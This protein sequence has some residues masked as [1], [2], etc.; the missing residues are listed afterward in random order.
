MGTILMGLIFI[1]G[2]L[3]FININSSN[4]PKFDPRTIEITAVYPGASPVEVEQ[5]II[6]KVE[7]ALQSVQGLRNVTSSSSE[8]NGIIT[9][10]VAEKFDANQVLLK[11][12]NAV[13]G[14]NTFPVGMEKILVTKSEFALEAV[15]ISIRGNIPLHDLLQETRRIET[16]L[17]AKEGVSKINFNGLPKPE[18]EIALDQHK[19]RAY[20][21]TFEEVSRKIRE[22]NIDLT[23]GTIR[24]DTEL[25]VIRTKQKK[26]Y[27][28][29]LQYIPI[30]S[31]AN[32]GVVLLKDVASLNETWKETPNATY[33][34]G[35]R[36][37]SLVISNNEFEDIGETSELIKDYIA[38]YNATHTDTSLALLD[39]KSDVVLTMKNIL[40]SNGLQGFALVLLF[41]SLFL[42]RRLSFW[43]AL[44]IPISI[45]G[46]FIVG[47][48]TAITFNTVSLFG[49]IVV[50][51]ILVDDAV[52]IAENI[53]NHYLKGKDA[54]TAAVDG[55]LEVLPSVYSGVITT[56]IAF[57]VFFYLDG[58]MGS[59]FTEMAIVIISALAFS[60][61][62]GT[63]IL[64]GH[65][66]ESKALNGERKISKFEQLFT[67]FFN[68]IRDQYFLPILHFSLKNKA[69][70]FAILFAFLLLT[71]G[72]LNRGIIRQ[73]D[74]GGADNNS[75]TVELEMPPGTPIQITEKYLNKIQEAAIAKGKEYDKR[76]EDSLETLRY[77]V[78]NI[79]SE[80]TGSYRGMLQTAD[81]RDYE[82][83][84]FL[85]E[86][87]ELVG[88]IPEAQKVNYVQSNF[89]GKP[90][91]IQLISNDFKILDSAST[92]LENEL[93]KISD[94]KNVINNKKT[95]ARE[96]EI[97]LKPKAI[98]LGI[99]LDEVMNSV[100]NGFYGSEAMRFSR[101]KEDVRIMVRLAQL[102]RKNISNL[103]EMR[104][105]LSNGKEYPLSAIAN[106]KYK[107]N[108][109]DIAHYN[110]KR[111]LLVEADS[112]NDEV[113]INFIKENIE[114]NVLPKLKEKY[115]QISFAQS[116]M[117]EDL[118]VTA[119]SMQKIGPIFL[120]LLFVTILFTFRSK[121]QTLLVFV[122]V[123]FSFI[124]VAWGHAIHGK[125]IGFTSYLGMIALLGV[126]VNNAIILIATYNNALKEGHSVYN[127]VV[128]ASKSRF[129]PIVLT[130]VTTMSGLF[131][132]IFSNSSAAALVTPMAITVAYGLLIATILSLIVLPVLIMVSNNGRYYLAWLFNFEKPKNKESLEPAISEME[133][134]KN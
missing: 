113:N 48:L 47:A 28:D 11:V 97:T 74:I 53:Y 25:L 13:D 126:M 18:I 29:E 14:I 32:G 1:F 107:R 10:K 103:E 116:G 16:E 38:T 130:T 42:N 110:G 57:T 24:G 104:I 125:S 108:L 99:S 12:K 58:F 77:S 98:A 128:I 94:L 80:N 61:F 55:T 119:K 60:L 85:A 117:E 73:G 91:S 51:G 100:R 8:D 105:L 118:E 64:P 127:A 114:A 69:L 27:A 26:Y 67:G 56:V 17:L 112:K 36:A 59:F 124:G 129:R 4:D 3:S 115:P 92:D 121:L 84:D 88:D 71:I 106:F 45:F 131:P 109:V 122:L 31:A 111:S 120:I 93:R 2:Y 35:E 46:M 65:I 79:T 86:V 68:K 134:V 41:L 66:A 90:V 72:S 96:I 43:V 133:H 102:G 49:M 9:I 30:R 132:L 6:L 54:I 50:L 83:Q 7:N 40:M 19:M 52:V 22:S 81:Y 39:D 101:D 70:T 15:T 20:Q 75:F 95:G 23:G 62:E 63:F 34:N 5:S 33:V 89:W 78:I 123:P 37:I 76:R 87:K 44:G 82:A 21:L